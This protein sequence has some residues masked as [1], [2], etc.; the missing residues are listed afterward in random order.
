MGVGDTASKSF[1]HHT[2][3]PARLRDEEALGFAEIDSTFASQGY[4]LFSAGHGPA[5]HKVFTD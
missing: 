2:T 4:Q 5:P 3:Q 1:Q